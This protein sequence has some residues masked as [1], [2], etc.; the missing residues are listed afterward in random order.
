[1]DKLAYKA[2]KEAIQ[3]ALLEKVD[4]Y[5]V[6][7]SDPHLCEYVPARYK[8]IEWAC[9][10]SGS[11]GSLIYSKDFAH[12]WVD[13]RYH[14][15]AASQLEG[16]GY[17]MRAQNL[18]HSLTTFLESKAK[19]RALK[20]GVDFSLI[21]MAQRAQWSAILKINDGELVDI[22]LI[23]PL[24]SDRAETLS[25]PVYAHNI[26]FA[27]VT[28]KEKLASLRSVMRGVEHHLISS[29]E[30]IAYVCNLR[31]DDIEFNPL[32]LSYLLISQDA[33]TLF[34][35]EGV[36]AHDLKKALLSEG[37]ALENYA[38]LESRLKSLNP[39]SKIL[40]DPSRTTAKIASLCPCGIV[41]EINPSVFMK[42]KKSYKQVLH[43]KEAMR[44]DGVALVKFAM[45]LE[46][47]LVERKNDAG[48]QLSE[49]DVP[50]KLSYFRSQSP[51]YVSESFNA[52]VGFNANG[53]QPHYKATE[54]S[55]AFIKGDGLLLIDSGAQY[56]N[57][58][59]DIT[60]VYKVGTITQDH[61]R[62]YTLVL[63]SHIALA[64]TVFPLG[65]EGPMLDVI[66]R[67][68]LWQEHLDYAHGTG[69]GVGYFLNVHEGPQVISYYSKPLPQTK[70]L[71]GMITSNEPGIYRA[72][73]W[74]VRLENLIVNTA[75]HRDATLCVDENISLESS[76]FLCFKNLTLFPFERELIDSK[77]LA[78]GELDWLNNYH[79]EVYEALKDL[80]DT[81]QKAWL[82]EKTL[83]L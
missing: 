35:N 23:S 22:D 34:V 49:L 65:F 17:E 74:G 67:A 73:K 79:S 21:S 9:G 3:N 13:G 70:M 58:T 14:I 41:E 30:D 24:W 69:H 64:R 83:P 72:D 80:L 40:L 76:K 31:G 63:K 39:D 68:P 66:S 57:G 42:S 43:V 2:R 11:A 7:M 48:G 18:E 32:F 45:W 81:D 46:R 15:Q 51:L 27:E 75:S 77:M 1:M 53:A 29:L 26:I 38:L 78:L 8:V 52:I 71:P 6:P 19:A 10:F 5:I 50:V 37:V 44:A 4:F 20:V 16:T 25:K 12:L 36:I 55:F 56:Q 62:D 61:K 59:T 28:T 82:R 54:Q 33:A 60:R 47:A